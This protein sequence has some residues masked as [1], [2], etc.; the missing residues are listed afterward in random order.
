MTNELY[1]VISISALA[2]ISPGS[3][4]AMVTK[5]T[6]SYG[7]HAGYLTAL[8]IA[9]STWVHTLYCLIGI[10]LIIS[11]TPLLFS[12]IKYLGIAYLLYIGISTFRSKFVPPDSI[13]AKL[14]KAT[15]VASFKQGFFSNVTNPK[16]TLFYLSLFTMVVSKS[17]PIIMQI[18][19]G[20]I[21]C[22][23]HFVWFWLISYLISHPKIK[24]KFDKNI[25]VVNK[26]IGVILVLI[27]AKLFFTIV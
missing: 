10:A 7:R 16:T 26:L 11:K 5:N 13:D 1:L 24:S 14:V 4:F 22:L 9:M 15:L 18:M 12:A 19:Y 25:N 6:V 23:L 17:T 21:I 8:G 20:L 27:A 3:D 2:V